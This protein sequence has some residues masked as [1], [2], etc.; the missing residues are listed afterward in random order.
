VLRVEE[1]R[2]FFVRGAPTAAQASIAKSEP[3]EETAALGR[4]DGIWAA[5]GPA[6][7]PGKR[8]I[9]SKYGRF[10]IIY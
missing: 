1:T 8:L 10:S 7:E 9:A 5:D 2:I 6:I 4:D 3:S